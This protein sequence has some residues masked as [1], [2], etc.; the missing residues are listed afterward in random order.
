MVLN[1]LPL[2]V[3]EFFV[4]YCIGVFVVLSYMIVEVHSLYIFI[5]ISL[6]NAHTDIQYVFIFSFSIY[7]INILFKIYKFVSIIL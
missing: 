7:N 6:M 5:N 1:L 4:W 3:A 2:P